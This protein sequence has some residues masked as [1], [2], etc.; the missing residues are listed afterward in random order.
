MSAIETILDSPLAQ[1]TGW[2]LVHVV[3]Q[4]TLVAGILA[5][6]LALMQRRSAQARYVASCIAMIAIVV[7]AAVTA[8]RAF[9]AVPVVSAPA[10][11]E[12]AV[13]DAPPR[14][15]ITF[16]AV[17]T[18]YLPQIVLA[19]LI[20]VAFL[21]LRL[22]GGWIRAR[23]LATR[24][25]QP[26]DSEWQESARRLANALGITRGVQL[27][28]SA[29]V[30]VP[31]VLGCLRPIVLLP[32]TTLAGLSPEQLEM[33]LAHELAHIRRH[34]FLANLMQSIVETLL[35]YHPAVW[36]ISARIRVEREHCCDDAAVAVCGDA[37]QYAR[38]LTRLEEL[39]A[40]RVRLAIAANGGSLLARIRRLA[41]IRSEA[42][43]SV[44]RW[45]A[46]AA[47]LS[48]VAV[49]LIAP[50]VP[51][52]A[53]DQKQ[54]V[55]A[56]AAA[57]TPALP[58][59]PAQPALPP[60]AQAP[61]RPAGTHIEVNG[62]D[63]VDVP[64]PPD[65]PPAAPAKPP[66][67]KAL[68]DCPPRQKLNIHIP[69]IDVHV[70]AIEMPDLDVEMPDMHLQMEVLEK[71][72]KEFKKF[73]LEHGPFMETMRV[74]KDY[75]KQMNAAGLKVTEDEARQLRMMGVTPRYVK[76]LR[77][78]GLKKLTAHDVLRLRM[79]GVTASLVEDLRR[80]E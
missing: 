77:D 46:G 62:D 40:D 45:I 8:V 11:V 69:P 35:F 52:F 38:A 72:N 73:D 30:E 71:M 79:R 56:P 23:Q 16:F 20:G 74:P 68:P 53:H 13:A 48:V 76:S 31:T 24:G 28:Q 37:L 15:V 44:S 2:A 47:L 34:D 4:A 64:E 18:A 51:A 36:W 27:L 14:M 80:M 54:A 58:A 57:V 12:P 60:A 7:L 9:D 59:Q 75:V 43:S 50:S 49:L 63:D 39:R 70:P 26:A 61:A 21:S 55:P 66:K 78:A 67:A 6:A 65:A 3:W 25:A 19:W 32:M 33:I 10:A 1:A 29:T 42:P 41:G 22:A 5:A 17:M